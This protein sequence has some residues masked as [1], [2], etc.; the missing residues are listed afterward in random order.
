MAK[1]TLR[2]KCFKR[3]KSGRLESCV[4]SGEA[5]KIYGRAGD[6]WK[7]APA[8]L[9]KHGYHLLCFR[10]RKAAR[11]FAS[12]NGSVLRV[13]VRGPKVLPHM[14]NVVHLVNGEM[15]ESSNTW[16]Q[17]TEM[18]REVRVIERSR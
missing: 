16:P 13:E 9:A 15:Y 8:W 3:D 1:P 14:L 7:R 12:S 11:E 5:M 10:T 2:W 4:I 17:G 6:G 18:W